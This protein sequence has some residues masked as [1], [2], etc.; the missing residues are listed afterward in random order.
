MPPQ[1]FQRGCQFAHKDFFALRSLAHF[2]L[3]LLL[4]NQSIIVNYLGEKQDEGAKIKQTN[5]TL[6]IE[7]VNKWKESC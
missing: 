3:V 1:S 5:K 6:A 2:V 4:G 7:S